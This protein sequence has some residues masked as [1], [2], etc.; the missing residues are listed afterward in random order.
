MERKP[1]KKPGSYGHT[2]VVAEPASAGRA[3]VSHYATRLVDEQ[4]EWRAQNNAYNSPKDLSATA[5]Q[6][7]RLVGLAYASRLYREVEALHSFTQ[8]S[9]QGNEVA[10]GTIGNGSC[11]QGLF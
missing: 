4:G 5:G 11:A 8:F 10:F 7:P 2:D 1:I 3:M 9:R 6:M